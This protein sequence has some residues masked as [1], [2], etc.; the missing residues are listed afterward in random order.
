MSRR[1]SGWTRSLLRR[2]L[3]LRVGPTAEFDGADWSVRAVVVP[4]RRACGLAAIRSLCR[5]LS[6]CR[7]GLIGGGVARAGGSAAG[8]DHCCAGGWYFAW[9]LRPSSRRSLVSSSGCRPGLM[10]SWVAAIRSLCRG[11]RGCRLGLMRW[12]CCM[13]RRERGW[14]RSLLRRRLSPVGARRPSSRRLRVWWSASG[15]GW[16]PVLPS[17]TG[18]HGSVRAVVGAARPSC[19]RP[20]RADGSV[21][22]VVVPA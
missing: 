9:G 19:G 16:R 8:R 3:V 1:E 14:T 21:R 7:L 11:L 5:G 6:G 20:R 22:A 12:R 18:A 4:A 15:P 10:S 2:R 13:R 17:A